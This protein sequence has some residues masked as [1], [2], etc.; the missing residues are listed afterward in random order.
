[1]TIKQLIHNWHVGKA[2][3]N[4][5]ERLALEASGYPLY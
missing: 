3:V 5:S 4:T 1:M 2:D